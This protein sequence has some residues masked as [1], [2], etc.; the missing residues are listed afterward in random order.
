M[1]QRSH[2]QS[3]FSASTEQVLNYVEI[4]RVDWP[5]WNVD[6][7]RIEH[8]WNEM[9]RKLENTKKEGQLDIL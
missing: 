6:L 1:H 2:T 8:L 5:I 3:R 4:H 7:N 9:K